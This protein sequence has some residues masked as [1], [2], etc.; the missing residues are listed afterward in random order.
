MFPGG[1]GDS[2]VT[3]N[4]NGTSVGLVDATRMAAESLQQMGR[5]LDMTASAATSSG[6]VMSD[7]YKAWMATLKLATDQ[8]DLTTQQ[9]KVLGDVAATMGADAAASARGWLDA[10]GGAADYGARLD[11]LAAQVRMVTEANEQ[12]AATMGAGAGMGGGFGSWVGGMGGGLIGAFG[13]FGDVIEG[14]AGKMM[15]F[16]SQAGAMVAG[17]VSFSVLNDVIQQVQGFTDSLITLNEQTEKNQFAWRYLYGGGNNARGAAIAQGMADWT[18]KFSM[19]IPY[20]R[21]DLLNAITNLAPMGLSAQGLEHFMPT[22]ADLAATRDPNANLAQVAQVIMSASMGYTRM[23]KYDLKI[24]PA[25]LIQY[26]LKA[27]GTGTGIH[28]TDPE[29]LLPA[30]QNYAKAHHLT[31]AAQDVA[32]STFWGQWSSFID[33]IQNFELDTGR[34]LFGGLKK[35]LNDLSSWI[36]THAD[37][38][39]RFSDLIGNGLG[40]AFKTATDWVGQFM[41]GLGQGGVLDWLNPTT[42]PTKPSTAPA[43]PPKVGG[44]VVPGGARGRNMKQL[45]QGDFSAPPQNLSAWQQAGQIIGGALAQ[46]GAGWQQ[47]SAFFSPIVQ[48]YVSDL[49]Q[50]FTDF[51]NSF[52]PDEKTTLKEIGAVLLSIPWLAL[53]GVVIG[54]TLAFKAL[55]VILPKVLD[56]LQWFGTHSPIDV[57]TKG[58]TGIA[59]SFA[60]WAGGLKDQFLQWGKDFITNLITGIKSQFGALGDAATG[61]AGILA[62]PNKHSKPAYGPLA[63]DDMWGVHLVDNIIHGMQQGVGRLSAAS[64]GLASAIAGGF[65]PSGGYLPGGMGGLAG[66]GGPVIVING[67]STLE[68]MKLIDYV[69]SRRDA[70]TNTIT[71][72]PGGMGLYA[73]GSVGGR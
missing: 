23:L 71:R 33:R 51:K 36:D 16:I 65:R 58:L 69:L 48:K 53:T 67:S 18:K 64:M 39:S 59:G 42:A 19:Q 6:A 28:I 25:E 72:A 29:T 46:I 31:G 47:V 22:I 35:D 11:Y 49:G 37:Q 27:T 26:G 63:D 52:S 15:G 44:H 7:S 32:H 5:Q 38:I 12:M 17:L 66:G 8:M 61:I 13:A 68:T 14:A 4:I 41:S 50:A 56:L 40:G 1:G 45:E 70:H 34:P 55:G 62:G 9:M 60:S 20:T 73:F 24:N 43:T 54:L 10:A 30:L 57:I 2:S 3:V 21:Q